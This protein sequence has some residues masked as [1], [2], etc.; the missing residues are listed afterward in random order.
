M[1]YFKHMTN[2][3]NDT[4]IK[5]LIN[6]YGIEGYGVYNLVLEIIVEKVSTESPVP[7]LQETCEDMAAFYNGNTAKI[8][9]IVCFCI[10][11]GLLELEEISGR[12]LCQKIYKFFDQSQTRSEYIR[13]LISE[14]KKGNC[15]P[16]VDN[17]GDKPT[18]STEVC[19]YRQ[20]ET[21]LK[22]QE[23]EQ[24]QEQEYPPTVKEL[25][26]YLYNNMSKP[27]RYTPAKI[28]KW[29]PDIDKMLRIDKLTPEAVKKV[30][31]FATTD[32]F[33]SKNILSAA[34]LR[35]QYDKLEIQ[36]QKPAAK[37]D[38]VPAGL[39]MN[40]RGYYDYE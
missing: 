21:V 6:K 15:P 28:K 31:D 37:R 11:Q 33:W 8:N 35:K 18:E 24:E 4:K 29:M 22:E 39:K 13:T 17:S 25:T 5:R 1:Q 27:T 34:T 40:D 36:S 10:N 2:M 16:I 3:R 26:E 20:H 19:V 7:D 38:P 14:Y 32:A 30:I 9:E 23:Q 12:V